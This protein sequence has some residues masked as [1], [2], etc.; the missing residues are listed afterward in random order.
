M[1]RSTV[2][3]QLCGLSA[4]T[5]MSSGEWGKCVQGWGGGGGQVVGGGGG[6]GCNQRSGDRQRQTVTPSVVTVP[7][8]FLPGGNSTPVPPEITPVQERLPTCGD[9]LFQ[10]SCADC[11]PAPGCQAVRLYERW[12][13]GVNRGCRAHFVVLS[14]PNFSFQSSPHP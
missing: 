14:I 8:V 12:R 2:S 3:V 7:V 10:C 9:P 4:C 6:E 5:W 11:P 13:G 1:W